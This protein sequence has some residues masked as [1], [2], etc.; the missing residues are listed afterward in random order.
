M[1]STYPRLRGS[2][3]PWR[4]PH[5]DLITCLGP[6]CA[7]TPGVEGSINGS[8]R[9]DLDNEPQ[10]DAFLMIRS[11]S[12][13]QARIDDEG[14]VAGGPELIAE[15]AASSV[16]YDLGAKLNVCRR[17]GVREYVVWRVLDRAIDWFVLPRRPVRAAGPGCERNLSQRSVSG[18]LAGCRR[19]YFFGDLMTVA[20]VG[21]EGLASAVHAGFVER[22]RRAAAPD[23]G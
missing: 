4:L 13:G 3:R 15:V 21:Q 12:G 7:F 10:P 18:A 22:L 20:R 17:S 1:S 9:L 5:F 14:Y 6:Y 2:C 8:L 11:A 19:I 16:S 23:A